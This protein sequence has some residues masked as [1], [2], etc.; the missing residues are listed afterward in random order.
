MCGLF[1]GICVSTDHE[2]T[3]VAAVVTAMGKHSEERGRDSAGLAIAQPRTATD[4]TCDHTEPTTQHTTEA[5][6]T[7]DNVVTLRGFG[8]F[9]TLPTHT[10]P[11][12]EV[13]AVLLGHTRAASQGDVHE[14][15][16]TSPLHI[17]A[18]TGTHNG[19]VSA[20]SVP[21][22]QKA[23]THI[24]GDT[25]SAAVFA[26]L[27]AAANDRRKMTQA[28]RK[29][30]GR[31]AYAFIDRR[32]PHRLYLVRTA[33]TPLCFTYDQHGNFYYASNPDWF[34]RVQNSNPDVLFQDPT[35]LPE[36]M[37]LTIDTRT[38]EP[39]DARRFTP[40]CRPKDESIGEMTAYR[41]FTAQDKALD[42][43]LRRHK[44]SQKLPDWP[45][46]ATVSLSRVASTPPTRPT[47]TSYP[48]EETSHESVLEQ[49]LSAEVADDTLAYTDIDDPLT[50]GQ[51][52][53]ADELWDTIERTCWKNG[54]FDEDR[55]EELISLPISEANALFAK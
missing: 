41:G 16:N 37:L 22:T 15:A 12:P 44:V 24:T 19:D 23:R 2:T 43:T 47:L 34:R 46:P 50:Q 5:A 18:I 14:Y 21:L 40:T 3:L 25:D 31:G 1:G 30:R 36:G 27:H 55:F 39:I 49:R 9:H 7:I 10:L 17:G 8:R 54:E 28:F 6:T 38:G 48:Q 4:D 11:T 20:A 32:S 51:G 35:L 26:A 53:V 52:N 45:Q 42:K 29:I 13:G 33:F